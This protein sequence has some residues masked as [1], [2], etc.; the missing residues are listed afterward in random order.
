MTESN[1][2]SGAGG[3][4]EQ[5]PAPFPTFAALEEAHVEFKKRFYPWDATVK[6]EPPSAAEVQAFIDRVAATGVVL[7]ERPER[8]AAQSILD[9]WSTQ[10][11]NLV[12]ANP[13]DM[14][15]RSLAAYDAS[16]VGRVVDEPVADPKQDGQARKVIRLA[17]TARLYQDSGTPGFLLS[18][19]ALA[20]ARRFVNLDEDIASLVEASDR[21]IRR[22]RLT[23]AAAGIFGGLFVMVVTIAVIFSLLPYLKEQKILR[24]A[25][26][27]PD[28][29]F[30]KDGLYSLSRYQ[31]LMTVKDSIGLSLNVFYFKGIDVP[32]LNLMGSEFKYARFEAV[33]FHRAEI[34]YSLFN[35]SFIEGSEFNEANLVGSRFDESIIRSSSFVGAK[36]S[37]I[38]FIQSL[39]CGVDF[40]GS[41]L[42]DTSFFATSFDEQTRDSLATTAWWLASGWSWSQFTRLAERSGHRDLSTAKAF[43][44]QLAIREEGVRRRA[45]APIARAYDLGALALLRTKWG[46]DVRSTAA[47]PEG[48]AEFC[49]RVATNTDVPATAEDATRTAICLM[50]SEPN[51]SFVR[52]LEGILGYVILHGRPLRD[53]PPEQLARA[54]SL[55]RGATAGWSKEDTNRHWLMFT[56]AAAQ[57][58]FW[59]QAGTGSSAQAI[60]DLQTVMDAGHIPTHELRHL[61]E[62]L[63]DQDRQG[64]FLDK[65]AEAIKARWPDT[66][67]KSCS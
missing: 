53:I 56:Y 36:L 59:K 16:R 66:K 43:R 57:Y 1:R 7:R 44:D 40:S 27:R 37:S 51:S 62:V 26:V 32:D 15:P 22:R 14:R 17:A 6:T 18:G 12:D 67:E 30:L 63:R 39:L 65:V 5:A 11:G 10:L 35:N 48:D 64:E 25:G 54:V 38:V 41:D 28:S 19:K 45:G 58:L 8:R 24:M 3:T 2:A 47:M 61:I 4:L 50:R 55:L 49:A 33:K 21:Y 34:P 46:I 13:S 52:F 9:Y 29:E 20:D 42:N 60:K 31:K 23:Y